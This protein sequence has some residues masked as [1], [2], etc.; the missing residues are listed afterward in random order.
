MGKKWIFNNHLTLDWYVGPGCYT[1]ISR[2]AFNNF[3]SY[4]P[5]FDSSFKYTNLINANPN[6]T[7]IFRGFTFRVGATIGYA[8]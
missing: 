7:Q 6:G 5:F 8:F 2:P 1:K 4:D 3:N